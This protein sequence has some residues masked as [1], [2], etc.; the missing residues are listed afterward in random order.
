MSERVVPPT[1]VV[2]TLHGVRIATTV[3]SSAPLAT[4]PASTPPHHDVVLL[5][6]TGLTADDWSD[7]ARGLSRDHT[8][9]AVDLR[10]HGRSEWPGTY[11][12]DLM[13]ADVIALI[14][15]LPEPVDLIGHSLGGLVALRAAHDNPQVCRLV[16]EDVGLP[17][18]R[19]PA[20]PQRPENDE[21]LDFDWA[22]VEQ[23]RPEIDTPTSDWPAVI[24]G[25]TQPILAIGGGLA[26]F[27]P[28]EWISELT[29][30]A[31]D[32]TMVTI[33]VGHEVHRGEPTAYLRVVREFL[34][35]FGTS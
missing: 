5:H 20:T 6:G 3:W 29:Q 16:L 15:S 22:V 10:G 24:E 33:P 30:T 14:E 8:V 31:R 9:H 19:T 28:Q 1:E 12:I 4:A 7:V 35:G 13:A 18:Q 25:L 27:V 21:D 34:D 32:A 11:S 23:V 2:R 17:H 26:S